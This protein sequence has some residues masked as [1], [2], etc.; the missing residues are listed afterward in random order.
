MEH[1]VENIEWLLDEL[2]EFADDSFILFD[3]PGQ[4]EL[5]SHLD[6]MTRLSAAIT[7]SGFNLCAAYCCDG[8]N[9]GEPTKYIAAC[10]T[11]VSTMV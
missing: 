8:T 9:L 2:Q 5:Y 7:K 6:V 4:V 11:S 3:C 1:L 10:L